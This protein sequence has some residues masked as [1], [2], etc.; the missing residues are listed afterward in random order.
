VSSASFAN[1][2]LEFAPSWVALALL[3]AWLA[4]LLAALI[5]VDWPLVPKVL[6][7]IGTLSSGIWGL[8]GLATGVARGAIRRATWTADG[9][10]HLL[11]GAGH[12]WQSKL[13]R[14]ARCWTRIAILVWDDGV[15][16]RTAFVTRRSAGEV[17]FRRLRVRMHFRLPSE[18]SSGNKM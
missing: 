5:H 12:V 14:S 2:E 1:I 3:F 9:T 11:N 10:W 13:A 16:R 17:P 18:T 6:L 4:G 7:G 15:T 8:R